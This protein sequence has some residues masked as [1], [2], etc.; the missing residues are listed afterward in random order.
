MTTDIATGYDHITS[1]IGAVT[2][3]WYGMAMLCYVRPKEHLGLRNKVDVK[4]GIIT[5]KIA[6]HA[7]HLAKGHPG[8]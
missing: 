5:Y 7:A 2:I 8:A 6:A 1:G 4:D 3:G